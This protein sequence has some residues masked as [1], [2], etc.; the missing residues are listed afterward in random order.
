M[1]NWFK[2]KRI[3]GEYLNYLNNMPSFAEISML[4]YRAKIK[5]PEYYV[6]AMKKGVRFYHV[7]DKT[8]CRIIKIHRWCG[9][10]DCSITLECKIGGWS[11][12]YR[13]SSLE[14]P[15]MFKEII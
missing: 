7:I 3:E 1:F 9:Q 10:D 15:L 14:I 12:E 11:S 2:R 4:Q 6:D 13:V 8:K 5:K